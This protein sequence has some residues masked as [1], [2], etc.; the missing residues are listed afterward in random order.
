[1]RYF[2]LLLTVV[3]LTIVGRANADNLEVANIEMIPGETKEMVISLNNPSKMYTAFQL[4]LVLPEGIAIA[5][6]ASN[7]LMVSLDE[8]R[9]DGDE[10]HIL[11][12]QEVHQDEG[13]ATKTY[14][15]LAYS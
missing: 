11:T 1:M 15:F 6:N 4:D 9:M 13:T 5:K 7:K 8:G 2:R 3:I 14:R 12:V 10:P